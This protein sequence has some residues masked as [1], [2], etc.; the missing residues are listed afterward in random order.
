[1]EKTQFR[2]LYPYWAVLAA[3]FTFSALT[4]GIESIPIV[5]FGMAFM[6]MI[7]E[8]QHRQNQADRTFI[9]RTT[10]AL[11]IVCAIWATVTLVTYPVS[12][13]TVSPSPASGQIVWTIT[14]GAPPYT[15]WL[16]DNLLFVDYPGD[17]VITDADPGKTYHLVVSNPLTTASSS[18][19]GLYYTYPIEIWLLIGL[20]VALMVASYFVPFAAFGAALIGGFLMLLIGPNP[21]YAGYLRL[22]ACA[23]FIAGL[24]TIFIGGNR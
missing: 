19:T 2:A 4:L 20:F 3:M 9:R 1:M 16:N 15:V 24:G 11:I 6:V 10:G 8:F 21:D 13:L 22:I 7:V 18:A 12:A 5:G 14:D 17:T 23:T